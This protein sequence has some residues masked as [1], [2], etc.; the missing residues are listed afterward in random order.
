MLH[1]GAG[2]VEGGGQPEL[3]RGCVRKRREPERTLLHEL[4]RENLRTF[5]A[6]REGPNLPRS[7]R[8]EFERYLACGILSEGF[9]RVH[10]DACGHDELVAFSCKRRGFCP[11]CNARRMHHTAAHLVERVFPRV[12][13]RQW[14]LSLPRWARWLLAGFC[15]GLARVGDHPSRRLQ[16]LSER[17]ASIS[18]RSGYVRPTLWQRAQPQR[19]LS[20]RAT[21]RSVCPRGWLCPICARPAAAGRAAQG[22]S[23]ACRAPPAAASAATHAGTRIGSRGY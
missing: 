20:L 22:S 7:V 18:V 13:V 23:A 3:A 6:E 5:L 21:R 15:A 1:S 8:E 19:A 11:S 16:S 10:C 14:V 9:A 2:L 12:P 4:V 17:S